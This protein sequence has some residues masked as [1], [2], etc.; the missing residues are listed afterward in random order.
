MQTETMLTR[1][2]LR[3]CRIKPG[4]VVRKVNDRIAHGWPDAEIV[5]N[6][7]I[8]MIEF[9]RHLLDGVVVKLA[10][11]LTP[12]Q[13]RMLRRLHVATGGRALIFV[14][15]PPRVAQRSR[16]SVYLAHGRRLMTK[17]TW[18]EAVGMVESALTADDWWRRLES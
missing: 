7:R 11:L 1:E 18:D 8:V 2:F 13:D 12:K 10:T 14:F 5:G 15:H 9:K 17:G 4:W 16:I 6:G 3:R